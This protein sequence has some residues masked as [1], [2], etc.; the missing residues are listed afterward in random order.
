MIHMKL[1]LYAPRF[2]PML[3]GLERV[4][5]AW[6]NALQ[7]MGHQVSVI[8]TTP[9]NEAETYSFKLL[10][11]ISFAKQVRIIQHADAVLCMNISLKVLPM[12][13]LA[14]KPLL[15]S[16]HTLLTDGKYKFQWRQQA[17]R[18]ICNNMARLNICCSAFVAAPLKKTTVVHSPFDESIFYNRLLQKAQGSLL[19]VGRLVSD[20]GVSGLLQ[21][22]AQAKATYRQA[23]TLTICG[24]GPERA[25][26]ETYAMQNGLQSTVFFKGVVSQQEAAHLM[27]THEVLIVPSLVEPFGTVVPEG[28]ACG[29][30]VIAS[31][32]GGLPEAAGGMA[33]MVPAADVA[34][35]A[36]AIVHALSQVSV[37]DSAQLTAHLHTLNT[38]VT[39]AQIANAIHRVTAK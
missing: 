5:M 27:N 34:A 31:N 4:T 32:I 7:S 26:L 16:H 29:C 2:Y 22:F 12:L 25:A 18:W 24:E 3:G 14:R 17:K 6:A 30:K 20:K 13:L 39:A 1:I 23:L 19:F 38:M 10:R 11:N 15:V 35:L 9:C 33:L 37:A 36:T 8:T 21:A 28:L